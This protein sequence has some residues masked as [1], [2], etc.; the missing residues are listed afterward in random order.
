MTDLS[1]KC[2]MA[3]RNMR[4]RELMVGCRHHYMQEFLQNFARMR[5]QFCRTTRR[6]LRKQQSVQ[7]RR[8]HIRNRASTH[9]YR[10]RSPGQRDGHGRGSGRTSMSEAIT[11]A[12]SDAVCAVWQ[13]STARLRSIPVLR[14]TCMNMRGRCPAMHHRERSGQSAGRI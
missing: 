12:I 7:R 9:F 11:S 4:R 14:G 8:R 2:A 5:W 3:G 13:I 1:G 10:D 6:F